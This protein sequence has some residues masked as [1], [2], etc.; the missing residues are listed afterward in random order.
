MTDDTM[1]N[2][3][4]PIEE[5]ASDKHRVRELFARLK[6]RVAERQ[7]GALGLPRTDDV[8]TAPHHEM[9]EEGEW[10]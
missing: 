9:K 8:F 3:A 10:R 7:A 6:V 1:T 4:E 2:P 5:D